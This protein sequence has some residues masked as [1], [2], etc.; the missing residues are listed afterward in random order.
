MLV[1][2]GLFS[3]GDI[4]GTTISATTISATTLHGNGTNLSGVQ[5]SLTAGYGITGIPT[6]AV[7]L[8]STTAY[9]T[10]VTIIS[11]ATYADIAGCSVT[12]DPGT[13]LLRGTVVAAS[14]GTI[15]QCFVAIT[16]DAN[17]VISESAISRPASGAATL[18]SPIGISWHALVT[19]AVT[20]TYKLRGARG[21]STHTLSWRA[22]DGS[23]YNTASHNTNNSDKGTSLIAIR[24]T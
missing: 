17:N 16:D 21:V 19:P 14:A 3:E 5:S 11:A 4:T 23:G 22:Y 12:L 7:S 18:N 13:W 10:E 20:T 24:I 9:A 1:S 2:E 15:I 6:I 8:S